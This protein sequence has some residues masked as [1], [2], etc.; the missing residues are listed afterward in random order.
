MFRTSYTL[1]LKRNNSP[2]NNSTNANSPKD[3]DLKAGGNAMQKQQ[4]TKVGKI[5]LAKKLVTVFIS[6]RI[7]VR[8]LLQSYDFLSLFQSYF[9]QS[10]KRRKNES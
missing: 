10:R 6:K 7:V 3:R 2:L 4:R 8:S 1:Y 5:A 9:H